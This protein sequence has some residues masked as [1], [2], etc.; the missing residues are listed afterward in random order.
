L[1]IASIINIKM[2]VYQMIK[3]FFDYFLT[4][5]FICVALLQLCLIQKEENVL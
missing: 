4:T 3:T 1:L 5:Q 2:V